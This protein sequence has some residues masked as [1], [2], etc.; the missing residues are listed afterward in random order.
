[1]SLRVRAN[2]HV[3]EAVFDP[4]LAPP[5]QSCVDAE[6]GAIAFAPSPGGFAIDRV[7]ELDR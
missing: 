5:V 3:G 2:G 7:I 4:P 6:V 1:M